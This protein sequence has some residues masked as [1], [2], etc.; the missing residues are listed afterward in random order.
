MLIKR[1]NMNI[2]QSVIL[3]TLRD[4]Y[5][6][7]NNDIFSIFSIFIFFTIL[8]K[9][10]VNILC[11]FILITCHFCFEYVYLVFIHFNFS[12][13]LVNGN[14]ERF[15]WQPVFL[16]FNIC[17]GCMTGCAN[18]YSKHAQDSLRK[19]RC[20]FDDNA[21]TLCCRICTEMQPLCS[22][23]GNALHTN[24]RDLWLWKRCLYSGQIQLPSLWVNLPVSFTP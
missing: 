24:S 20:C 14:W 8:F 2:I 19:V 5:S 18:S 21:C 23:G 17:M 1:L 3:V 9:V 11:V 10:L 12:S 4:N 6:Y 15:P 22:S 13:S 16:L 7:F